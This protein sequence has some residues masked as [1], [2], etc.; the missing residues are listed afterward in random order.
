[1]GS[2]ITQLQ[3][4]K[5]DS[6]DLNLRSAVHNLKAN[7]F[8]NFTSVGSFVNGVNVST[9]FL[10]L[11]QRLNELLCEARKTCAKH[12]IS[13]HKILALFFTMHSANSYS[14]GGFQDWANRPKLS[15]LMTFQFLD[16]SPIQPMDSLQIFRFPAIQCPIQLCMPVIFR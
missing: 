11:L 13:I 1:M 15:A 8:I 3:V 5:L 14:K 7:Y 10:G 6:L 12:V 16:I 4:L 9:C 2:P